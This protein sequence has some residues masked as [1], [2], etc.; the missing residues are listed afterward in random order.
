MLFE[1]RYQPSLIDFAYLLPIGVGPMGAAFYLWDS[2]L[3]DGDPRVI[4]TLAYLA[5]MFSTLA[6]AAFGEA[7]L[8]F[9]SVAAMA[10][11]VSGAIVGTGFR[12]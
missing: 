8:T 10:L 12:R 1:P 6:I 4:G 3:K 2:A 7:Q 11:I 9:V 5:P